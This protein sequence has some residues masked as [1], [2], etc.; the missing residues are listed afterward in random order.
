LYKSQQ[1]KCDLPDGQMWKKSPNRR[2]FSERWIA[3]TAHTTDEQTFSF[4][5]Q[6]VVMEVQKA[7]EKVIM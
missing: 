1:E 3:I 5:S 7:I 2:L 6:L 4:F